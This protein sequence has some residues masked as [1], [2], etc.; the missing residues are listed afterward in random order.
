MLNRTRETIPHP[1]SPMEVRLERNLVMKGWKMGICSAGNF[2]AVY[3][4]T[5]GTKK[6]TKY[7]VLNK[8]KRFSFLFFL[9][10]HPS[11][12][13]WTTWRSEVLNT[14]NGNV[15]VINNQDLMAGAKE[16]CTSCFPC[17]QSSGVLICYCPLGFRPEEKNGLARVAHRWL[18]AVL[19]HMTWSHSISFVPRHN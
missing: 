14:R 4:G 6:W 13:T 5:A 9:A 18:P 12:Y 19:R 7:A 10:L 11:I 2:W 16:N 1:N 8:T 17:C 15:I 3:R